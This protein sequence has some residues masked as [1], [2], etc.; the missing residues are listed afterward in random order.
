MK[1]SRVYVDDAMRLAVKEAARV[2][3]KG[4]LKGEEGARARSRADR[5][6]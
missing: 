2:V 4:V 1:Q 6:R 5:Q 3:L